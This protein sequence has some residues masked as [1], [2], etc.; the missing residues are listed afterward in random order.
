MFFYKGLFML[1]DY[2][3]VVSDK[4]TVLSADKFLTDEEITDLIYDVELSVYPEPFADYEYKEIKRG[5]YYTIV[6]VDRE[7]T[8][9]E[10]Y[11]NNL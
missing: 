9:E 3:D 6:P 1:Y 4:Y 5:G 10:Y 2:D 8:D 7:A 11:S